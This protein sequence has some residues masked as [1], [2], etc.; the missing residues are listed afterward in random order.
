MFTLDTHVS[1][2]TV[3]NTP[4]VRVSSSEPTEGRFAQFF[5][6]LLRVLGAMHT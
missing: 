1:P 3:F 4:L 2:V 5:R 6:V